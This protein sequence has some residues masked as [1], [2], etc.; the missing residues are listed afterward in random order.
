MKN[1]NVVKSC[2]YKNILIW[3]MSDG[4]HIIEGDR[5]QGRYKSIAEAKRNINNSIWMK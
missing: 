1:P 5:T 3:K 4:Q 2:V